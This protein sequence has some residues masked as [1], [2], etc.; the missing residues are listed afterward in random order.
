M[1]ILHVV[2]T[3]LPARRYGGPIFAVHGLCRALVQRGHEVEVFTTDVDG[4]G[5][6]GVPTGTPVDLDGVRVTYFPTRF[7][8]LYWSPPMKDGLADRIRE[9]DLVHNHSVFLWPT[10]AAATAARVRKVP[11]VIS[12]RG[13]L[14][15]ELIRRRSPLA[16]RA[17]IRLVE[18]RNF[19]SAAAIHFTS[20]LEADEAR[21][22]GLPIPR[23][24]VVPN[25]IDLPPSVPVARDPA[26]ILFLGR[27][28]WKKG[29]DRIITAL[30][31]I[32]G[33]RL[34]VAG[35]DDESLTPRLAELAER[36]RVTDRIEFTGPVGGDRKRDLLAR[37]T[38][39][40]LPSI[41]E[42]FGNVVL[43]AMA[44]AA[45]VVVTP[46]V[47]LA[48]D[49]AKAR[50]GLVSSG[51]PRDLAA[52][53]A[54]IVNDPEQRHEMGQRARKLVEETFTWPRIAERM[55][56]EYARLL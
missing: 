3:Y 7:R 18:Q 52:A 41:S 26:T 56:Q 19:R 23:P 48:D 38:V 30:P 36:L 46:E 43:E 31:M 49:V 29:I 8:R 9:F 33:A 54:R 40:V 45:P 17:W 1:R 27:I 42:N 22:V 53:I 28:T 51:H 16:K 34:I 13:M 21:R 11:Y 14:V 47:G 10:A 12:P 4:E 20:R 39:V 35:N 6:S 15:H 2:P 37:A 32:P 25:G 44:A 24:F 5:V 50:A 55:E